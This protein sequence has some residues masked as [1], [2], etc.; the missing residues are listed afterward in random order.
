MKNIVIDAA[1]N[2]IGFVEGGRQGRN[3]WF[4]GECELSTEERGRRRNEWL[5]DRAN[6]AKHE[7]YRR[8]RR[9][10]KRVIRRK[11]REMMFEKLLEIERDRREG[12]TR[13]QYKGIRL[14]RSGRTPDMHAIK[15][16]EGKV[17]VGEEEVKRRWMD[18]YTEL[19]NKEEP[20]D[21][22]NE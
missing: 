1:E 17:L 11:K 4:D 13:E 19:L 21:P 7:E 6:V 12:R 2:S 14:I 15:D 18:Y 20:L 5:E 16:E 3:R 9:E 22:V 10:T 8:C